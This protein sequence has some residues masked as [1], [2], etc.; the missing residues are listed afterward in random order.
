[1]VTYLGT[2]FRL[3]ERQ[4]RQNDNYD[5]C[6]LVL[7]EEGRPVSDGRQHAPDRSYNQPYSEVQG[8]RIEEVAIG[9]P[10][11]VI[12]SLEI[13]RHRRRPHDD[14]RV[15]G[16]AGGRPHDREFMQDIDAM[17]THSLTPHSTGRKK[18]GG[19]DQGML[20]LAKEAP[21]SSSLL[22]SRDRF[23]RQDPGQYN[24]YPRTHT[25]AI[26]DSTDGDSLQALTYPG[27]GLPDRSFGRDGC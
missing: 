1:M 23:S 3:F 13:Y 8:S 19:G 20:I 7:H 2:Y 9:Y 5:S 17:A 27:R 12:H 25:L 21:N 22:T 24:R 14:D 18:G 10:L 11:S 16:L 4:K 6:W 26:G 15:F